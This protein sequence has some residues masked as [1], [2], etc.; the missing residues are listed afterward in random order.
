MNL[1]YV[2]KLAMYVFNSENLKIEEKKDFIKDFV[3]EALASKKKNIFSGLFAARDS[4]EIYK[5]IACQYLQLCILPIVKN[6]VKDLI[7]VEEYDFSL[8]NARIDYMM[9]NDN[10]IQVLRELCGNDILGSMLDQFRIKS[11]L[12][13]EKEQKEF[14]EDVEKLEDAMRIGMMGISYR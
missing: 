2:H 9:N 12:D 11:F 14:L 10:N 13:I 1:E 6:M 3:N 4:K 8:I 7:L 5:E